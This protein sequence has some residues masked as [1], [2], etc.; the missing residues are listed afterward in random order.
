[1]Y[2]HNRCIGTHHDYMKYRNWIV[3][4]ERGSGDWQARRT[5]EYITL[6]YY[7]IKNIYYYNIGVERILFVHCAR[8]TAYTVVY[9]RCDMGALQ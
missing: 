5:R 7:N 9:K 8:L 2:T 6:Y 1:M 4:V 3:S